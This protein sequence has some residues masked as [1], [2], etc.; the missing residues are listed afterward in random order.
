MKTPDRKSTSD[1]ASLYYNNIS[2]TLLYPLKI[3]ISKGLEMNYSKRK[4]QK[5]VKKLLL[6]DQYNFKDLKRRSKIN[7]LKFDEDLDFDCL[8]MFEFRCSL[9]EELGLSI[10]FNDDENDYLTM[11]VDQFI[12]K[13][14]EILKVG[15]IAN[16]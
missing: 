7:D 14:Q 12:S 16:E 15:D 13:I 6:S 5:I 3:T 10:E 11:T 8:N 2:C 9:E 1:I 4:I